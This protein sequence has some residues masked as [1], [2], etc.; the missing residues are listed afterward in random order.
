MNILLIIADDLGWSDVGFHNGDIHTPNLDKIAEENIQFD[1]FYTQPVCTATRVSIYTGDYPFRHGFDG[2]IWPWSD[3]GMYKK[4]NLPR[5]LANNG[6]DTYLVGKW[7]VGHSRKKYLPNSIGFGYHY[8]GHTGAMDHWEHTQFGVHDFHENGKPIYPQGHSTDLYADKVSEILRGRS[9]DKPFFMCLA[10]NAPHVP[11]QTH[12]EFVKKYNFGNQNRNIFAGMVTHMDKKIGD[13]IQTLKDLGQYDDTIIW[14]TSDNGGWL[15]DFG[16]T[17]FPLKDGKISFY[18]GGIRVVNIAKMPISE[19]RISKVCHASDIFPTLCDLVGVDRPSVD[20][21]SVLLPGKDRE[22]AHH[23]RRISED[24]FVGCI[25]SGDW[26]Y[27]TYKNEE[28]YNIAEDPVES[29]NLASQETEILRT[30]K[31]R[32]KSFESIYKK[33]K[34]DLAW[35]PPHGPPPGFKMPKCWS[36]SK[37]LTRIKMLQTQDTREDLSMREALGLYS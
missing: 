30:L 21:V 18:E 15:G 1:Q 4:D 27:M 35:F 9:K 23:Y 26:K 7:N 3:F 33:E 2:V 16:G 37:N 11:L 28:L 29:K 31:V 13:L 5:T 34:F 25:R 19:K 14:F 32:L 6:Y 10:L 17:N 20:G 8:G 22:L 24:K 36:P 12:N